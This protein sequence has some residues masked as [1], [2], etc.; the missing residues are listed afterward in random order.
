MKT[1]RS[2]IIAL[3]LTVGSLAAANAQT[4]FHVSVNTPNVRLSAGNYGPYYHR[5]YAPVYHRDYYA[6]VYHR[7]YYRPVYRRGYRPGYYRHHYRRPV[8]MNRGYYKH[9]Y[10]RSGYYKTAYHRW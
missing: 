8:V 3:V 4:R 7:T 9:N 5:G 6:P 1:V 2:L 10:H